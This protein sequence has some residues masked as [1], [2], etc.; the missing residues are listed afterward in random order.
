MPILL[1]VPRRIAAAST[2][3]LM[4]WI[5]AQAAIGDRLA[6]PRFA[7]YLV[8][9]GV[10]AVALA[11]PRRDARAP[12]VAAANWRCSHAYIRVFRAVGPA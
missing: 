12:L 9:L 2:V 6:D 8:A 5:T 3:L 1:A 4:G 11:A 10:Q 7:A